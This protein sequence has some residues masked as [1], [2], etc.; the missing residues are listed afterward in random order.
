MAALR[1]GTDGVRAE[2]NTVLT[3]E[4]VTS[5]GRAAARSLGVERVVVG[6]D[7]RISGPLL[8]AALCAGFASEGV[9]VTLL[10]VCPTPAV[11]WVAAVDGVAGAVISASHNPFADNG[12]KLFAPGGRKLSDQ[13]QLRIEDEIARL[14]ATTS[15]AFRPSAAAVGLIGAT[16]DRVGDYRDAVLATVDAGALAGLRVVLDCANGAASGLATELF[17]RAGATV[18][19]LADAP[20]GTNINA[21]CGSTHLQG[22]RRAVLANGADL[23]LAFDGDADRVLAVDHTGAGIDGDQLI[24]VCALDLASRGLLV[25]N[26]V[27]VTVMANLGFRLGMARRG[28]TIVETPVG[29]RH[30]LEALEA[31]GWVLGGEQSGHVI[32]RNLATTG[33]GLLTGLQV[34]AVVTR[35]RTPLQELA[36]AAMTRMPQVL[37]N[38]R[39]AGPRPD[40]L[41]ERLAPAID[42][43]AARLGE[44]GRVLVRPSGTEPLVRVM[45]EAGDEVLAGEAAAE[46]VAAVEALA[47]P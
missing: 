18:V 47:N 13:V 33:D 35:T 21:D 42:A 19:T 10:G 39:L 38:V 40:G 23:G 31:G 45:V 15:D 3:P 1:F 32:F 11:A 28:V 36:D 34:A 29:D 2:A 26:T 4:F 16:P 46:L 8:E 22:L 24:A 7:T 14:S 12:I 27:V 44:Q 41:I 6:R 30:V 17:S 9:T 20:D 37:R 43:V 25:D 5:L